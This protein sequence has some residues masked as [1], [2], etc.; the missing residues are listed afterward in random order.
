MYLASW[1]SGAVSRAVALLSSTGRPPGRR[2]CHLEINSVIPVL[3]ANYP[4]PPAMLRGWTPVCWPWVWLASGMA[5]LGYGWPRV[6]LASG[7]TGLGEAGLEEAGSLTL[8]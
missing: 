2:R 5:G 3:V 6:R 4:P 7:M 1:S 8:R